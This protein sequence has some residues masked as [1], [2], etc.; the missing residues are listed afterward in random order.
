MVLRSFGAPVRVRG[1]SWQNAW[2][3]LVFG[4]WNSFSTRPAREIASQALSLGGPRGIPAEGG[5]KESFFAF[6][7]FGAPGA[8]T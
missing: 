8:P 1:V 3:I 2:D 7:G 4:I 6:L 5:A